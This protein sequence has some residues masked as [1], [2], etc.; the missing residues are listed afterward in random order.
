MLAEVQ[1]WTP[2]SRLERNKSDPEQIVSHRP[3]VDISDVASYAHEWS[4]RHA[5]PYSP[6]MLRR[7]R[8]TGPII[9]PARVQGS[10]LRPRDSG[11][12]TPTRH[13]RVTL[14]AWTYFPMFAGFQK[15]PPGST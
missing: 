6:L 5:E 10:E 7:S 14:S 8:V 15:P 2:S 9:H 13:H 3:S 4:P 12:G 1:E 11:Y